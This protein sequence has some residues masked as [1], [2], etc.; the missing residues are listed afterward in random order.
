MLYFDLET[1][2]LLPS[3]T[4]VHCL[5][6]IDDDDNVYR[7]HGDA[8]VYDGALRL[9]EAL[10]RGEAICGH[11][12]ISFDLPVLNKI[13][14]IEVFRTYRHLVVDTLVLSRLQYGNIGDTDIIT[15]NRQL[16]TITDPKEAAKYKAWYNSNITGHHSLKAWGYRLGNHKGTY[17]QEHEDCWAE[18]NEDMMEYCV[19]DVRVTKTLKEYLDLQQ[20][21]QKAIELEHQA[22]WLMSQQERNGFCFDVDKAQALLKTLQL[23]E[24]DLRNNLRMQVP[25][26]PDKVFVPKRDNK[27]KGYVKGV[28]VQRYKDFNPGSRDQIK[29]LLAQHNYEP[30]NEDLYDPDTGNLKMDDDTFTFIQQDPECPEELRKLAELLAEYM[31]V[32]KRIGQL[33]TGN[34]AWLKYLGADGRIH[35]TVN[36]CGAVSGRATHANPNIAQVPRVGN[37]YGKECRELFK[38]PDGWWQVGVDAS[39][40]E[41]RCLAH[42]L[43]PYDKGAYAHEILNGDIHTANQKA[44]GLPERNQAKT[45]IYAFLYGAGDAK[46]GRIVHGD[47]KDGKRL[48][49]EFLAKTPAIAQLKQ[50]IADTLVEQYH[51]KIKA[52]KRNY[53][54]G[55]DGRPL[56]VRSLHS[57]LNLLLQSAGALICK[58]WIC[59]V[60]ERMLAIGYDHGKDF[61]F[62]AWVHDEFQMACRTEAIARVAIEV[63]QQAMR[64]AQ[65]YYKF[66][67]QL[68]TEGKIGHNWAD[69]H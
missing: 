18:Y 7:Y 13:Y 15:L 69:C 64:E 10:E 39:G 29:W 50:A 16:K 26:I 22:Q 42:Y 52:W 33:A 53:L 32:T 4:K 54:K 56:H 12:I 30:K 47:A 21:P 34:K 31:L 37:P 27:T 20:Y 51:G 1:D 9:L 14:G 57:A 43:Y 59:L 66:R 24:A 17:A 61:L 62:M 28:P 58:K 63:G 68:D 45:F 46:I 2:G 19:Q 49:K 3:V 60:E 6:I 40:L 25:A 67:V 44:A 41:L 11:N 23:R 5:A 48:K 65:A 8:E 36:P 38:A 55:L 35:G